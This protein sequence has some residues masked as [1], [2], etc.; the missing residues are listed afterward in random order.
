MPNC[1]TAVFGFLSDAE[2]VRVANQCRVSEL[3]GLG[4]DS[5]IGGILAVSER[6]LGTFG[7]AL[8]EDVARTVEEGNFKRSITD[9]PFE[10]FWGNPYEPRH[11]KLLR[12]FIDPDAASFKQRFYRAVIP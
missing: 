10:H 11:S 2:S 8:L 3:L 5:M 7:T 4:P 12:Y 6:R 1:V 9:W